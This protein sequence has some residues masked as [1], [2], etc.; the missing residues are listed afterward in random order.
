MATQ[1]GRIRDG[2]RT[3]GLLRLPTLRG[4][5]MANGAD[6]RPQAHM[7]TPLAFGCSRRNS[8]EEYDEQGH[9]PNLM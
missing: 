1:A 6:G 4:Q 9:D 7:R 3:P 2:S 8:Q 5:R